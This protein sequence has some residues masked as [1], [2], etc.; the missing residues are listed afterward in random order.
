VIELLRVAQIDP[1]KH[2]GVPFVR[3]MQNCCANIPSGSKGVSTII[4]MKVTDIIDNNNYLFKSLGKLSLS[5][6]CNCLSYFNYL[7]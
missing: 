7:Q 2:F 5:I 3:I 1:D 6:I 4:P